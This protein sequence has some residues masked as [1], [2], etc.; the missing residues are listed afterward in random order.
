[1]HHMF[2]STKSGDKGNMYFMFP[3]PPSFLF[4]FTT[5]VHLIIFHS[6]TLARLRHL[7]ITRLA[8]GA[9]LIADMERA[10]RQ[11]VP[12]APITRKS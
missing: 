2:A 12:F 3:M 5:N 4:S 1:M 7:S 10:L 11:H 6:F 8:T 9:C